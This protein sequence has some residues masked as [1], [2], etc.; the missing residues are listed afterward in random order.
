MFRQDYSEAKRV[1]AASHKRIWPILTSALPIGIK[2][3]CGHVRIV[4]VFHPETSGISVAWLL[5]AG[6]AITLGKKLPNRIR[7]V[8]YGVHGRLKLLARH[9]KVV[10]PIAHFMLLMHGNAS[11]VLL[12][13]EGGIVDHRVS[14]FTCKLA[15]SHLDARWQALWC[16][17]RILGA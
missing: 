6:A 9:P 10:R 4:A 11:A 14:P 16:L 3:G 1:D 8:P 13:A 7:S 15:R 17:P 12:S 5:R 2:S